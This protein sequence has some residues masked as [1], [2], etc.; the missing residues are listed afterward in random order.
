MPGL[1]SC[2]VDQVELTASVS[3]TNNGPTNGSGYS[4]RF[5]LVNLTSGVVIQEVRLANDFPVGIT[6]DYS[7]TAQVN[8]AEILTGDIGLV[9][10]V[11]TQHNGTTTQDVK[12]WTLSGF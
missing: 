3:V 12:S 11:E 10:A 8:A 4:G 5:S 1:E 9:I 2:T 7:V 6:Q